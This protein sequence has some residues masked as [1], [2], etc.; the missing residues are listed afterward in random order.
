MLRNFLILPAVIGILQTLKGK[1]AS[2]NTLSLNEKG[3][4]Q[5]CTK[6]LKEHNSYITDN[7]RTRRKTEHMQDITKQR[8]K[9]S[10]NVCLAQTM[11][12]HTCIRQN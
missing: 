12:H 2:D 8:E 7:K 3:I 1:I 4:N 10:N 5:I 6:I 11:C 9:Q